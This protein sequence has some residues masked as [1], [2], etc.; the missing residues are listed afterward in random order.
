LEAVGVAATGL[1]LSS[2]LIWLK[3]PAQGGRDRQLVLKKKSRKVRLID[4]LRGIASEPH[5][6]RFV[7]LVVF[8]WLSGFEELTGLAVAANP[9]CRSELMPQK[10]L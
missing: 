6:A 8:S 10:V 4:M 7:V 2:E 3:V 9:C 5:L 1:V